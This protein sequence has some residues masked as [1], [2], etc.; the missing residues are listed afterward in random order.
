[1][2][3]IEIPCQ[4]ITLEG[5]FALPLGDGPFGLVVVCHP[6]P[7]YGGSMSNP[8]VYSVCQ[9]A[10]EKGLAWLKFNF[11]GVGKSGGHFGGG[12]DEKEDAKAAISFGAGQPKIDPERIGIC[13][14]SFGSTVAFPVAVEDPRVKAV[15]GV[16]PFIRPENLLDQYAKPKFF[17]TGTYDEFISSQTLHQQ[18]QKLPDPKELVVFPGADHFWGGYEDEM[19]ESVS[20]FFAKALIP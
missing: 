3:K 1:M 20:H 8:V 16:S 5:I 4:D 11:R 10:E 7:L 17:V 18:V 13:G 19:A 15:A 12:L 9:K 6:H 2:K 14:Y